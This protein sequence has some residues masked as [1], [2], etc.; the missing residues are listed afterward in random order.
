MMIKPQFCLACNGLSVIMHLQ[1]S[2]PIEQTKPHFDLLTAARNLLITCLY[3]VE[4]V[5]VWGHQD[6]GTPMALTHDA[7][8]NIK[9][10][11]LAKA[12]ITTPFTGLS[13]FKLPGNPWGCYVKQQYIATQ[14]LATLRK[15]INGQVTLSY[16][17]KQ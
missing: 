5:F 10:N 15:L 7:W 6:N 16:W 11:S 4:L 2:R 12:K 1:A 8:L 9:A 3:K 13:A 17:E 14:L